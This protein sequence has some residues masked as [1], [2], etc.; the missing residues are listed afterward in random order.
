MNTRSAVLALLATLAV[1]GCNRAADTGQTEGGASTALA[2]TS[3]R[4]SSVAGEPATNSPADRTPPTL[5][6]GT[7]GEATGSGGCNQYGTSYSRDASS[8]KF[9][10]I[11]A[12]KMACPAVMD[13]ENAFFNAL[14]STRGYR[15][16]DDRLMLLD[17]EGG[18]LARLT[19]GAA[20]K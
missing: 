11:S 4:L 8:L 14:Q 1:A 10:P 20:A 17:G 13:L 2:G 3:W 19:R 16:D 12:T 9:G 6:F 7:D 18:E 5:R 15:V